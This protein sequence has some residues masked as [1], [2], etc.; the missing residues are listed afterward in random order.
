MELVVYWTDFAKTELK[1]IFDYHKEE[2]GLKIAKQISKEIVKSTSAL[3]S[4]PKGGEMEEL[5]KGK[6]QEFRYI[7]STHY[8]IIYW[9]NKT[10]SRIE[11]VDVFDTRQNPVKMSRNK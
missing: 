5:L 9:H 1:N 6:K 10:E 4:F 3:S 11:I 7:V 2:V 8:K